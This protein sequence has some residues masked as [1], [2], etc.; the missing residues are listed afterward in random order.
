MPNNGNEMANRYVDPGAGPGLVGSGSDQVP[1]DEFAGSDW[2]PD[3]VNACSDE[4]LSQADAFLERDA[5][6]WTVEHVTDE[7]VYDPDIFGGEAEYFPDDFGNEVDY[8]GTDYGSETASNQAYTGSGSASNQ[9]YPDNAAD[10]Y[11][12]P[13]YLDNDVEQYLHDQASIQSNGERDFYLETTDKGKIKNTLVN[14]TTVLMNDEALKMRLGYDEFLDRPIFRDRLPWKGPGTP[15]V[16]VWEDSDTAQAKVYIAQKYGI[17]NNGQFEVALQSVFFNRNNRVNSLVDRLNMLPTWD[18]QHR[19]P[20]LLH[21]FLGA[22]VSDYNT[23]VTCVFLKAA[24]WR[25]RC[26][27]SPFDY[28]PALIGAQGIGKSKFCKMLNLNDAFYSELKAV[29]GKDAIIGLHG[30]WIIEIGELLAMKKASEV[31]AVK[32]FIT[33]TKDDYRGVYAR[34]SREVPRHQVFI[35]TT[36]KISFLT[37][38]TGNRRWLPIQCSRKR[39]NWNDEL[40]LTARGHAY[41]EQVW[42]EAIAELRNDSHNWTRT[43]LFVIPNHVRDELLRFQEEAEEPDERV[44]LIQRYLESFA[45][46]QLT[47]IPDLRENALGRDIHAKVDRKESND[48]ADIM[49]NQMPGWQRVGLQRVAGYGPQRCWK[50]IEPTKW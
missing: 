7:S 48:I 19:I 50:K 12:S 14:I 26:G 27:G 35:A 5:G 45:V 39:E 47:C 25:A 3:Q 17:E 16:G 38:K 15:R 6:L 8:G 4:M 40:L 24:L 37:D 36:N 22:D 41:I 13:V 1:V 28:V 20:T 2:I 21:D 23:E 9:V 29:E 31:E 33:A 30:H 18:G 32:A 42:S 11:D 10:T 34:Y 46:G 49:D 44:G 43:P